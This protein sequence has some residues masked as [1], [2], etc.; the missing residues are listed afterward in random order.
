MT[1]CRQDGLRAEQLLRVSARAADRHDAERDV[2]PLDD[3]AAR[4]EVCLCKAFWNP[5][6]VECGEYAVDH[7]CMHRRIRVKGG[8]SADEHLVGHA[9][10]AARAKVVARRDDGKAAVGVGGDEGEDRSGQRCKEVGVEAE[11][12]VGRIRSAA[13]ALLG[14]HEV[15]AAQP[16]QPLLRMLARPVAVVPRATAHVAKSLRRRLDAAR[17]ERCVEDGGGRADRNRF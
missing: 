14:G 16:A 12:R 6:L 1:T 7:A 11:A 2:V 8:P 10:A 9:A 5:D 4:L 3:H 13:A 15:L 17:E